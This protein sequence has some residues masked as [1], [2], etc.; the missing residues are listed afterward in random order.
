MSVI[1]SLWALPVLCVKLHLENHATGP[2]DN[3]WLF[4]IL[5]IRFGR[6]CSYL[7]VTEW[8]LVVPVNSS[9]VFSLPVWYQ[10]LALQ[11]LKFV[12]PF[13]LPS[14][15]RSSR[16]KRP[17]ICLSVCSLFFLTLIGH[18]AHTQRDSPGDSG[19]RSYA[20]WSGVNHSRVSCSPC[21]QQEKHASERRRRR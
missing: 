15:E 7:S 16:T 17:S 12:L 1:W 19:G 10:D 2:E 6:R 11:V 5:L 21:I 8:G 20:K 9:W 4:I 14:V 18:V 3:T 13:S